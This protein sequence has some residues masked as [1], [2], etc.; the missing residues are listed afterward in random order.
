MELVNKHWPKM[1][2]PLFFLYSVY[3]THSPS[4]SFWFVCFEKWLIAFKGCYIYLRLFVLAPFLGP[5]I[6]TTKVCV[7]TTYISTILYAIA[8]YQLKEN[9]SVFIRCRF[10][11]WNSLFAFAFHQIGFSL[12]KEKGR[13]NKQ[14]KETAT[15]AKRELKIFRNRLKRSDWRFTAK[16]RDVCVYQTQLI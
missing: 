14:Q 15:T 8:Q 13:R 7:R 16:L 12:L 6:H 2:L 11:F 5:K 1:T 3:F 4:I 9:F 10:F